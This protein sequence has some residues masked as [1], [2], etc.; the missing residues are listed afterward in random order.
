MVSIKVLFW[1]K[2][3]KWNVIIHSVSCS[4]I[5]I[6]K[7]RAGLKFFYARSKERWLLVDYG[8][9]KSP[10][11]TNSMPKERRRRERLYAGNI[12]LA[13]PVSLLDPQTTLETSL[14]IWESSKLSSN[15][16][17]PWNR[18]QLGGMHRSNGKPSQA[19]YI[20]FWHKIFI[21]I[22]EI[23]SYWYFL[24]DVWA[25]ERLIW[26]NDLNIS[27]FPLNSQWTVK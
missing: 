22:V 6:L 17:A 8:D 10:T 23:Q 5:R 2:K 7:V 11:K 1:H 14:L 18:F 24:H 15:E 4:S 21:S 13:R 27:L 16:P 20:T 25:I 26:T 12:M 19:K 3:G 9:Q